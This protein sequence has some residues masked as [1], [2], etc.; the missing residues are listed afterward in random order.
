MNFKKLILITAVGICFLGLNSCGENTATQQLPELKIT[1]KDI[2]TFD[3][4]ASEVEF[5]PMIIPKESP[6]KLLPFDPVLFISDKIYFST[7]DY[8]DASVHV[9]DLD[10]Q[11]QRSFN[12]QGGGPGEYKELSALEVWGDDLVVWD[13]F[14]TFYQYGLE[15]FSFVK[16]SK[17]SERKYI[18]DYQKLDDNKWILVYDIEDLDQEGYYPVFHLYDFATNSVQPLSIK[19][20]ALTSELTEGMIAKIEGESYLLNFGA[21]DTLFRF[22]NGKVMPWV[23]LN[24]DNNNLP[25]NYKHQPEETIE[26]LL[27]EQRYNFNTGAILAAGNTI[28]ISVFGLKKVQDFDPDN[29]G[30]FPIY[31]VYVNYPNTEVKVSRAFGNFGGKGFAKDDYFYEWLY[32]EYFMAYLE[33]GFFGKFTVDLENAMEKLVDQEDPILVK[34]KVRF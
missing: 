19:A 18:P 11:Y 25:E 14:G 17:V 2:L 34:Y 27:M 9:F 13:G 8:N 3:Q 6:L 20:P 31:D 5:I 22:K 16:T 7:G 15:D 4:I 26:N 23:K 33:S 21:S 1:P 12:K 28:R 24:L 29:V 10:G 30:S 32:A